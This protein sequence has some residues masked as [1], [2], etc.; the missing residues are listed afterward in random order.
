MAQGERD[1]LALKVWQDLD[2]LER[3][4]EE[5]AAQAQA[6]AEAARQAAARTAQQDEAATSPAQPAADTPTQADGTAAPYEPE[7][8]PLFPEER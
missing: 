8:L 1:Q 6:E 3:H 5:V 4:L 7:T 2:A